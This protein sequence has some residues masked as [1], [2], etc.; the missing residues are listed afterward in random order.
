MPK[1]MQP[2]KGKVEFCIQNVQNGQHLKVYLPKE[3]SCKISELIHSALVFFQNTTL[4]LKNNPDL[5]TSIFANSI[6]SI[7]HEHRIMVGYKIARHFFK[8]ETKDRGT[9]KDTCKIPK[10]S[11]S[12]EK[13]ESILHRRETQESYIWIKRPK[14]QCTL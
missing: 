3:F 11:I 13:E 4:N 14:H 1:A 6:S 2:M 10:I 7:I 9:F 12:R 5:Q 8:Q